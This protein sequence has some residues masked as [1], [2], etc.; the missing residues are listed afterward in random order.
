F[1]PPDTDRLLNDDG[2]PIAR[3]PLRLAYRPPDDGR[4]VRR[5]MRLVPISRCKP[6]QRLA[7]PIFNEEG[8]VLLGV[9]MEVTDHLIRRLREHGIAYVYV[10]DSRTDD[11]VIPDLISRD[12]RRKAMAHVPAPFRRLMNETSRRAN[13]GLLA[14]EFRDVLTMIIDVLSANR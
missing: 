6:G 7:R 5:S 10:R 4:A 11:V 12:A 8:M 2:C 14:R 9:D 13:P 1:R 3:I